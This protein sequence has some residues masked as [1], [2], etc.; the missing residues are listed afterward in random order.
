MMEF[1]TFLNEIVNYEAVLKALYPEQPE[2]VAM[3]VADM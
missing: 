1:T 2:L 3:M